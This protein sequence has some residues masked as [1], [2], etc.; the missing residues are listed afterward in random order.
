MTRSA[1]RSA[2]IT[3]VAWV[4]AAGMVGI[5]EASMT[6]SPDVPRTRRSVST[7]ASRSVRSTIRLRQTSDCRE[8]WR[9]D[10][11]PCLAVRA[12]FVPTDHR[13]E[14]CES[15]LTP[16]FSAL[17][18][19]FI[20]TRLTYP[21]QANADC[22]QALARLSQLDSGIDDSPE[23]TRVKSTEAV[24]KVAVVKTNHL[25]GSNSDFRIH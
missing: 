20:Y 11:R 8:R 3:V 1:P 6:R 19:W 12:Q 2:I 17:N 18:Q 21:A 4:L 23:K 10:H 14:S 15:R 7:T 5:T 24:A 9:R 22:K 13:A 25:S 16:I